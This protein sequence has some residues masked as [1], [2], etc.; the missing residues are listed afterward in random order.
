MEAK[1]RLGE[2]LVKIYY[3]EEAAKSAREYL[4]IYFLR[5]I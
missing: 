4:K 5:K 3:S 2:E 1:K